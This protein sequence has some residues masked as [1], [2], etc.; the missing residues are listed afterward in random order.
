MGLVVLHPTFGCPPTNGYFELWLTL[1]KLTFTGCKFHLKTWKVNTF[2]KEAIMCI[3]WS[4]ALEL[5]KKNVGR[6]Y[7][8][9]KKVGEKTLYEMKCVHINYGRH[10]F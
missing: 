6:D 7:E 5:T 3:F 1:T 8:Y 4:G 2:N 10:D 9:L